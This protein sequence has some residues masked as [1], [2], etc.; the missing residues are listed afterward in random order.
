[1]WPLIV[2]S[3]S[4]LHTLPVALASLSREHVQDNELIDGGRGGDGGA[5]AGAVPRAA[6]LLP[7]RS[8]GGECQG[9]ERRPA[10]GDGS[11]SG[12][13]ARR[14]NGRPAQESPRLLDTFDDIAPWQAV[15]S[16]G[17]LGDA[18]PGRRCRWPRA[19]PGV[20]LPRRLRYAVAAADVADDVS[21]E[22]EYSLQL[23]GS[24][25]PNNLEFKLGD[26]S[27][28]NVWWI[29]K[30]D[31]MLPSQWTTTKLKQAPDRLRLGPEPPT[32]CCH[33]SQT[34]EMTVSAGKG[35]KGEACI[36]QLAF[37]A[38]PPADQAPPRPRATAGADAGADVPA[39]RCRRRRCDH[40]YGRR[41]ERRTPAT[42]G[43][44][45]AARG[46][47]GGLTP[48][49]GCRAGMPRAYRV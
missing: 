32:R 10:S 31:L 23:R 7:A 46:K 37:R 42:G 33:T 20:R 22:Y 43:T 36:G 14:A 5:G 4:D 41:P 18:A 11:G 45:S 48:A 34:F 15:A 6:A 30:R 17:G 24:G 25:P 26:A 27:G 47:F 2:L 8:A 13:A 21:G 38:L 49:V 9:I 28:D 12:C 3:D 44:T 35:G 29:Q 40:R 1:M 16:D 39:F 19:L